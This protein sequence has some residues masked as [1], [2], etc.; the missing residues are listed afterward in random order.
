[1][2][3]TRISD[4]V[5]PEVWTPYMLE[6]WTR[7]LRLVRAGIIDADPVFA[8]LASGA[9][10]LFNLPFWKELSGGSAVGSDDPSV[11]A[12]PTGMSSG[13]DQAVKHFRTKA[14]SHMDIAGQLAGDDPAAA[15]ATMVADFWAGDLQDILIASLNGVF[16]DN[17]ANDSG[18]MIFDVANDDVGAV[19]AA[20]KIGSTP[21]LLARQTMGDAKADLTA[22]AMHSILHTELERQQLIVRDPLDPRNV[23]WGTYLDMTVIVDDGCPAVVGTNRITYT[24]YLFG[25][26]AVAFGEGSPAM[27]TET[28][29]DALAGNGTGQETLVN[30]R[31]FI[32]HPRGIK[33]T[34]ASV[35]GIS[36]TNAELEAA[37]NWDRAYNRK[38]IKLVAIK[39]NG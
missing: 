7:K 4:V 34:A 20:E 12:T 17:T 11:K 32:L 25:A 2:A 36:P 23:G 30:R 27:P 28:E 16:A 3:A 18:D 22:I 14:W 35:A 29:R 9:G 38:N 19:Q 5:V 33:F 15:L 21:I 10:K 24:S 26:G 39:T 1:M 8:A 13:Q 31:E 6:V 37:A